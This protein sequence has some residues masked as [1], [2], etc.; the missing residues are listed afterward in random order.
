MASAQTKADCEAL[1]SALLPLAEQR[2]SE[3]R[4]L[5]P[6]GSAL[7]STDEV[8]EYESGSALPLHLAEPRI[9]ELR[10]RFRELA[11]SG[12]IKASALAYSSSAAA[13]AGAEP[14]H[15]VQILLDHRDD[16]SLV[17]TFP[18]HWSGSELVIDEPHAAEGAHDI[19]GR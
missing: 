11:E 15:A 19:F 4:V 18:Y 17:V 1:L 3:Q 2:L 9:A 5:L 10:E 12:A 6:F 16:Y 14:E 7:S 13:P 8:T